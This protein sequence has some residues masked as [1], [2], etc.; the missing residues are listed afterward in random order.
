MPEELKA[1][2]YNITIGWGTATPVDYEVE[3]YSEE[4][5]F[6]R[7]LQEYGKNLKE[8]GLT[9]VAHKIADL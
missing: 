3:A 6:Q 2:F 8:Q 7:A 5:A 1:S 9:L 4:H